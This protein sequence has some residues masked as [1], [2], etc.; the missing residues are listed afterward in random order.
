MAGN[1]ANDDGLGISARLED[2]VVVLRLAG[3]L[4]LSGAGRVEKEVRKLLATG[5]GRFE[6]DASDLTFVDSAGLRSIVQAKVQVEAAG[7]AFRIRA[8]SAPVRRVIE[9]AGIVEQLL[10]EG[11]A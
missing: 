9:I 10:P 2:G 3:E 11:P 5:V 4:D 1:D 8:V 6:V 7:A